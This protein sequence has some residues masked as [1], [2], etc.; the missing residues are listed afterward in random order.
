MINRLRPFLTFRLTLT[1][2]WRVGTKSDLRVNTCSGEWCRTLLG[3]ILL[4]FPTPSFS[5]QYTNNICWISNHYYIPFDH[6][7]PDPVELQRRE[8]AISYYQWVPMLLLGQALVAFTPSMIWRFFNVRAGIDVSSLMDVA[9]VSQRAAYS[10]MRE[11]TVRYLVNQI[12]RYLL[13][14]RDYR[15]GCCV[16]LKQLVARYCFLVGGKRHG[17]YLTVAYLFVKF[18]YA[19]NAIGQILLLDI[20]M[21]GDYHMYG[22]YVIVRLF[23]GED[24]TLLE[25]FPR[26]TLCD[27][28]IRHNA[29]LHDY[30]VQC[31]LTI[32]LFNEKIFL[33]LWYW[34]VFVALCTIVSSIQWIIR[35]LYW[36]GQVHYVKKKLRAFDANQ[37][38]KGTVQKFVQF[39]LRRDGIFLIRLISMNISDMIASEALRGLWESYGPERRVI[40]ENPAKSRRAQGPVAVPAPSAMGTME[41]VWC[42][43]SHLCNTR[44]FLTS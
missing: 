13:A 38:T 32:N 1:L 25:R 43:A 21:G 7:I 2:F 11:K 36:P 15:T 19:F 5:R 31:A 26:V 37:R 24:W 30:V 27:F 8:P 18:L 41:V 44:L 29:R 22:V 35:S 14:Q 10:E 9:R 33:M 42:M 6:K 20:F 4:I 28:K 17:N 16:R 34:W 3:R 12:D 39:Y 23:R 40:S